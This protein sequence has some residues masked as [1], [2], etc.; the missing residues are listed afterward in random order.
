[1]STEADRIVWQ[2]SADNGLI[3]D[4][5]KA[6]RTV[7]SPWW[8]HLADANADKPVRNRWRRVQ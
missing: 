8:A 5:T 6:L 4:L 3:S 7:G 1:M 2:R